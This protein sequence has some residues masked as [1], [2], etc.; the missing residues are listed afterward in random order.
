MRAFALSLLAVAAFGL[1]ACDGSDPID[2]TPLAASTAAD[3]P[4]DPATGHDPNTGA[5]IGTTNQFTFYSL[6]EGRIV[7]SSTA[8]N[9]ADSASTDWDIAFRGTTI[10]IN[11]GTSGP[12]M[13]GAQVLTAAFDEVTEAPADGYTQDTAGAPAIPTGSGNGWYTYAN[14]VV[15][16]TPGRV[17]IIRTA[18]GRY[19]KVR[20]LGYYRGNPAT[21]D[22]NT[23]QDRYYTF[24]Y[25]FQPDGSRNFETTTATD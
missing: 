8:E 14:N 5:P 7:L 6:R 4:A 20:I 9:R 15:S 2:P 25:I 1:A 12:G 21:V 10:R 16:A 3:I 24:E 17:L 19:A 11:G 13:G 23:A 18:D 22:P